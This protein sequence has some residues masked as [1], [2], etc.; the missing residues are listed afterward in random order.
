MEGNAQP[1]L[2]KTRCQLRATTSEPAQSHIIST[3]SSADIER[4]VGENAH[5][6]WP[7][8]LQAWQELDS[9]KI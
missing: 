1:L 6:P 5:Q 7:I 9:F 8:K 4:G 2:F 3:S